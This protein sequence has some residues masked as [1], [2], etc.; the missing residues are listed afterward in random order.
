M[1]ATITQIKTGLATRLSTVSGLR[2]YNYQPD[3]LNPPMAFA[4]L[5]SLNY[6]R[7]MRTAL[8]EMQFTVRVIVARAT[9][10]PAEYAL[11]TYTSATGA[12]SIKEAIEGDR[13]LGGIVDDLIV[14]SATGMQTIT[15]NDGEY[16]GIDFTV[17][18][19]A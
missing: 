18:V 15:A 10:R 17:R 9:E 4:M 19:Y 11:D 5:E 12:G 16:L 13:T 8:T 6:H 7:T 3:Q 2:T 1:T 14:E